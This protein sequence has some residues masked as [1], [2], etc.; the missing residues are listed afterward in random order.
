MAKLTFKTQVI[1][2]LCLFAAMVITAHITKIE[3]L[4]NVGWILYGLLFL[5]H[6]VFPQNAAAGKHGKLYMRIVGAIVVILGFMI[7]NRL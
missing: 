7:R 4:F 5:I 6:P 3:Y 2:G 1:V